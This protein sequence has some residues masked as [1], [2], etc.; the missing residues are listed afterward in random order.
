[1][2]ESMTMLRKN[3]HGSTKSFYHYCADE[4]SDLANNASKC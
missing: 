3:K 1:M 4:P 2:K